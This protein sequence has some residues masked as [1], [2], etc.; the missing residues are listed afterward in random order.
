MYESHVSTRV[1]RCLT[2]SPVAFTI[3]AVDLAIEATESEEANEIEL[4]I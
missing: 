2:L 4:G 1:R 3:F